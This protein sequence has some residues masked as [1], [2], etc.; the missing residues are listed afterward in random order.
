MTAASLKT[1]AELAE[2]L[3]FYASAGVDE[4]LEDAPV[5]RFAEAR[6]RQAERAPAP[7][8]PARESRA[9]QRAP[10][11]GLNRMPE[12]PAA[13]PG[14]DVSRV[15]DAPAR[16]MAAATVPDEGQ[17][18][19]ARQLAAS[20]STLDELR[21]H[22]AA[23][24]GCNLKFTA[25]NLVFADGN[26]NA[27]LMLVGEAPGRDEDL[28]G[29]PFV[30]RSGRLLDLMLA[31]IGLDRTS[32]YIANVIPWRPPGNRTPTPHET[33]ICRPFIERQIE[34]VNPKVLVN[35]GGPSAK[36]LLN[37]TEGI[38]RLRGNWRVH[39]TASGTAIPA[40]PT[41][42]PAYLLRTPAHKKLAWRDFLE[43]KAKLRGLA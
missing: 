22:M 37:T 38:L 8:A 17:I 16:P 29:L 32:A 10:E 14:L 43:V 31:A 28:E 18:M 40:M 19:L 36:T 25:K 33:E 4:A 27:D 35:L 11:P 9:E 23:F 41:L 20:A 3:A 2:L 42:H 13:A 12:R 39:T 5:D 34:L 21:Q 26:P 30:G 15:P 6:P 24:D 7:V 1:P